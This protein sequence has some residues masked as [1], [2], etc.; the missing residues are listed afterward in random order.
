[1]PIGPI[2]PWEKSAPDTIK[3]TL[4]DYNCPVN[5]ADGSLMDGIGTRRYF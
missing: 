2:G 5:L 1:M 3:Q 4:I